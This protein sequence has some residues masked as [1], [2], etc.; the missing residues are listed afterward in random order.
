MTELLIRYMH[1][2]GI[3]ILSSMLIAENLMLTRNLNKAAIKKLAIIDGIYGMG[4]IITLIAG[5]LLWFWV[6]KPGSF[7]SSNPIFHAKLGLFVF[8]AVLS[9]VPTI[10]FLKNIKSAQDSIVVPGYIIFITRLEVFLLFVLPLLAVLMA[11][12]YGLS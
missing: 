12:G 8:I 7:Y 2:T 1:F 5:L 11:R 9:I 4:A 6:G 3:I 10:F